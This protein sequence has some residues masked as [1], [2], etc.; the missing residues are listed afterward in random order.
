MLLVDIGNTRIKWAQ[1]QS[2]KLSAYGAAL[3]VGQPV[4]QAWPPVW[5][6]MP[7]PER[8]VVSNV[9]GPAV[10]ESLRI[11]CQQQFRR[12]PEFVTPSAQA[13]GVIN[14][15]V[16]PAQLG[17]DRWAAVIGAFAR[18]GGPVCVIGCG[19]A[20]TVDTVTREGRHLGGLIAPGLSVMPRALSE[21]APVLPFEVGGEPVLFA[22]DTQSAVGSGV[23]Y[24]AVGF[25]ERV[26]ADIR[27][28]QGGNVKLL[29][30]GGDAEILQA[31]LRERF[32]LTPHLVLQGLVVLAEMRT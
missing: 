27:T 19:T 25:I 12:A 30:T 11:Y 17:A 18:Y 13:A 23:R 3:H 26:V 8:I 7:R 4:A 29:L 22:R 14:G 16:E 31:W 15:Y 5:N 28:Q 1:L 24:A 21:A 2:G 32:T 9:A 20:I 6:D 10:T